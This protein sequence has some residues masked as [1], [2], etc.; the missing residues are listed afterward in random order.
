MLTLAHSACPRLNPDLAQPRPRATSSP[1][2]FACVNRATYICHVVV[3]ARCNSPRAASSPGGV[4]ASQ[5]SI[6]TREKGHG[7]LGMYG[8][9][10]ALTSQVCAAVCQPGFQSH[11]REA[12]WGKCYEDNKKKKGHENSLISFIILFLCLRIPSHSKNT[13]WFSHDC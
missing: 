11:I 6:Y 10:V 2:T 9:R 8:M 7:S 12:R 13:E 3:S 4:N 5:F 1:L